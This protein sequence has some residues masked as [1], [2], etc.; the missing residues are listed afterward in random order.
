MKQKIYVP[1]FGLTVVL[2]FLIS[3]LVW[4][5][6]GYRSAVSSYRQ[7]INQS[8]VQAKDV[9]LRMRILSLGEKYTTW[10]TPPVDTS[11][12]V[13]KTVQT[14]DTIFKVRVRKDD[15]TA[16]P[17]IQQYILSEFLPLNV[18]HADSLFKQAMLEK[19]LPVKES[20]A[21]Y[22]DLKKNIVLAG[23]GPETES[24]GYLESD[25]DTLD[26]LKTIGVKIYVNVPVTEIIKP[27]IPQLIISAMLIILA[28]GCLFMLYQ[29]VT[30]NNKR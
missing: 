8:L 20:Y 11:A 30:A 6:D 4:L 2:A 21:E 17:K 24:S 12:F 10:Y 15:P 25:I 26:I 14:P 28:L 27:L 18:T 23:N 16:T 1:V 19:L 29:T 9:E 7:T 5:N 22:L 3:D 13:I